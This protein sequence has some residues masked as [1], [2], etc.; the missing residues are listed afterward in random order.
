MAATGKKRQRTCLTRRGALLFFLALALFMTACTPSPD[1][2]SGLNGKGSPP[3]VIRPQNDKYL[4]QDEWVRMLTLAISNPD[5][6]D[7]IWQSIPPGQR[8]EISLADFIR[9]VSFLADC[10]PGTI[11]SFTPAS[12]E[13]SDRLRSQAARAE[14]Q[15]VPKPDQAAIWWIK[16]R[17]SD[18]RALEFAV[19]VTLDDGGIPY[20]S[21]SWLQKQGALYDYIV[22]YMDALAMASRPALSSLLSYNLTI[23][24]RTQ[25]RA[26]ERRADELLSYYSKEVSAVKNSY[27]CIE[28][29]PGHALIEEQ[30]SPSGTGTARSRTVAF[31]ETDGLIRAEEKIPQK[32]A[33]LD[34]GLYVR[35]KALFDPY[36]AGVFV[37]SEDALALLG[38]PLDL[39]IIDPE[40]GSKSDF[41]VT[42]PGLVLEASGVCDPDAM[43]FEGRVQQVSVSYSDYRTG[44]GLKPGDSIYEVY[45][46]YPFARE[47]GYLISMSENGTRRTLAVQVESD[48]IARLTLIF[49]S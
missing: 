1:L 34:A 31:S 5:Q 25:R 3:F 49:D 16:A 6:R 21:K 2:P 8:S 15:L 22:L 20:F 47:N 18:L 36:Q 13:E 29:M 26:I 10:L 17:T 4:R 45:L 44:S 38:V 37:H 27:R 42:W 33:L 48:A 39:E 19:P 46:R 12:P 23:R 28:M 43:T 9:Y 14:K 7:Q 30:T 40:E 24:T 11:S 35:N 32:L 41:R